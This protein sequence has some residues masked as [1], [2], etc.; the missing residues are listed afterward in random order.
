MFIRLLIVLICSSVS[1]SSPQSKQLPRIDP[2]G[3]G[4]TLI[5][6][7]SETT[8]T[9][10]KAFVKASGQLEEN[11]NILFFSGGDSSN[12]DLIV[13]ALV[14][15]VWVLFAV[16]VNNE[17]AQLIDGLWFLRERMATSGTVRIGLSTRSLRGPAL[18]LRLDEL[19]K[20][21]H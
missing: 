20:A 8:E 18:E 14:P 19:P 7:G 5:L 13:Y 3:I 2:K 1:W 17:I 4:G 6:A 16:F 11:K 21:L 10:V 15:L 12:M 9:A